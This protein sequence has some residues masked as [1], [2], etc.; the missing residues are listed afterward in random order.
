MSKDDKKVKS[1]K[2]KNQSDYQKGKDS[3][4]KDLIIPTS[5]KKKK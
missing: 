1:S 3:K 4:S 2:E 5:D